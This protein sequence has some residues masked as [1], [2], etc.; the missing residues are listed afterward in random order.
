MPA[1]GSD[2]DACLDGTCEV[3]ITAPVIIPLDGRAAAEEPS[4]VDITES[5][6]ALEIALGS[7]VA[8]SELPPGGEVTVG[9]EKVSPLDLSI[10]LVD[11][12]DGA[13]VLARTTS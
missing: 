2:L 12:A 10:R 8:R 11:L 1:D 5:G 9:N 13:A 4:V 3:L 6:V 7:S